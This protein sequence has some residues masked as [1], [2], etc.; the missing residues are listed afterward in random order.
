MSLSTKALNEQLQQAIHNR[1]QNLNFS[2]NDSSSLSHANAI[3]IPEIPSRPSKTSRPVLHSTASAAVNKRKFLEERSA[4]V[5]KNSPGETKAFTEIPVM[6]HRL[7]KNISFWRSFALSSL[8]LSW[9][10]F[11]F[12]LLWSGGN[13]P[14]ARIFSNHLSAERFSEFVDSQI[15]DYLA[16]QS[17]QIWEGIPHI[18]S[19]L[20]V[21]VKQQSGGETKLRLI[22]DGRYVN[23]HIV[24]PSFKYEDLST[25]HQTIRPNDFLIVTDFSR[26]YHHI[27]LNPEFYTFFGFQWK[28]T[29][30]VFT[31]LP[32]G[33]ASACWA[34][35][36]VTREL[37]YKWRR[38]HLRCTSYLDDGLHA[39]QDKARL[40]FIFNSIIKPDTLKCG[41]ILN[42]KKTKYNPLHI[43]KYIGMLIDTRDRG[44]MTVPEHRYQT[45]ATLI[46]KALQNKVACPHKILERITGSISSMYWAFGP[47]ARLMSLS[48]HSDMKN[49]QAPHVAL[50]DTSTNDLLFWLHGFKKFERTRSIWTDLSSPLV[51]FTDAAGKNS[52]SHG[53]WAGW[54]DASQFSVS[55]RLP[56]T[57]VAR[58][59]WADN[60]DEESSTLLELQTVL[61]VILSFNIK[62]QLSGKFVLIHT[63]NQGVYFIINK[64][65]SHVEKIHTIAKELIWYCIWKDIT[66]RATWIPRDLN[67]WADYYSKLNDSADWKLN[68]AVFLVLQH[69]FCTQFEIDLFAS[70]TNFQTKRY[71]SFFWTP[72]ALGVD[73][74]NFKWGRKCWCYPPFN[75]IHRV[76]D[77]GRRCSASMGI[78][79][80]FTPSARWWHYFAISSNFLPIVRSCIAL[81]SRPELLLPGANRYLPG[82]HPKWNYIALFIDFAYHGNDSIP[83]SNAYKL[84]DFLA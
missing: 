27:D 74:F 38:Q 44:C 76:M 8:V 19:P 49:R 71:Y 14:S 5:F 40:S 80:P 57:F 70:Y 28:D 83:V 45:L 7:R 43:Q 60:E 42:E 68:P 52:Q 10:E 13:V 72:S 53:G 67:T 75:Q 34:F 62:E 82:A 31:S 37:I 17:I 6:R 54:M 3:I 21:D 23:D 9:I 64:A 84:Y 16:A 50:S 32:F 46:T 63:D 35:T 20:G 29:F 56:S 1:R 77:H 4:D 33:L 66:I 15:A 73:A 51:I 22:W 2:Q 26:G 47:L 24:I 25:I 58:G 61:N 48:I 41:F 65:G 39:H 30:Y 12:P 36:K 18:V 55:S 79:I 59:I 69:Q 78:L 81:K 11:G